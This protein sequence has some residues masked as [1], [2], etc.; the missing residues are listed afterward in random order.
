M[1]DPESLL[2]LVLAMAPTKTVTIATSHSSEISVIGWSCVNL[3]QQGISLLF[4]Y[5]TSLRV[6]DASGRSLQ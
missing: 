5:L 1:C 6:E 2:P 4:S 3:W